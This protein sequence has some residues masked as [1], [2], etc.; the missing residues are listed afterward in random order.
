MKTDSELITEIRSWKGTRWVHGQSLK[1][2]GVDCVRFVCAIGRFAGWVPANYV[3]PVYEVDWALHNEVSILEAE[4][5]K[6]AAKIGKP[7]RIGDIFLFLYGKCASHAGICI[8]GESMVHSYRGQGVV[9][10]DLRHYWKDFH[11]AWRP[12][13]L[14]K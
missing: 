10:S 14:N 11:S 4:I 6:F 2:V 8:G 3:V 13:G 9:E 7:F 12:R 5:S 1:G